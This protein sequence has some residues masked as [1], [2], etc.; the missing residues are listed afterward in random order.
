MTFPQTLV[1]LAFLR[2]DPSKRRRGGG[3]A[4]RCIGN[5][6]V[7]RLIEEP[8]GR[9]FPEAR[10]RRQP[11]TPNSTKADRPKKKK[12]IILLKSQLQVKM[13]ARPAGLGRRFMHLRSSKKG[14]DQREWLPLP[15]RNVRLPQSSPLLLSLSL[16]GAGVEDGEL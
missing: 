9:S 2:R 5:G 4:D 12:E 11:N 16:Q 3:S 14:S 7:S 15:W 10:I 8:R 6:D 1:G 13:A